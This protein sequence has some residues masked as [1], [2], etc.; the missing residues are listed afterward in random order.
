M[1]L[2]FIIINTNL[3]L[4]VDCVTAPIRSL[5]IITDEILNEFYIDGV[6]QIPSGGWA[7][8]TVQ[9]P[10]VIPSRARNLPIV[11]AAKVNNTYS[12]AGL[13]ASS[14]DD[15]ILTDSSMCK[16]QD[17]ITDPNWMLSNYND[18]SWGVSY[19]W[20]WNS[21]VQ[22]HTSGISSNAGWVWNTETMSDYLAYNVVFFRWNLYT[23]CKF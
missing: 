14:T 18:S 13:L 8:Y 17:G 16:C 6:N 2:S 5:F 4:L 21:N 3:L 15:S 9:G 10:L 19:V 1:A 11:I 12:Y 7:D 20:S 23:R 22:Y